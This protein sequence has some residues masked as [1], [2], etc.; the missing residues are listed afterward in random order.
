MKPTIT[1]AE[2][3]QMARD[4]SL[5]RCAARP[6]FLVAALARAAGHRG[7][8]RWHLQ[9]GARFVRESGR[10]AGHGTDAKVPS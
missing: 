1:A 4:A 6:Q 3:E 7:A 8:F 9:E 10:L 5:Y 2:L